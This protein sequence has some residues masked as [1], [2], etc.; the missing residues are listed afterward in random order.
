MDIQYKVSTTRNKNYDKKSIDYYEK[1]KHKLVK[2]IQAI[3]FNPNE[4]TDTANISG[5]S[6]NELK[7]VGDNIVLNLKKTRSNLIELHKEPKFIKEIHLTSTRKWFIIPEFFNTDSGKT[8]YGQEDSSSYIEDK[9]NLNDFTGEVGRYRFAGKPDVFTVDVKILFVNNTDIN[10]KDTVKNAK[11]EAIKTLKEFRAK[12]QTISSIDKQLTAPN[13]LKN[14]PDELKPTYKV[15]AGGGFGGESEDG[16]FGNEKYFIHNE[17]GTFVKLAQVGKLRRV[18]EA[19]KPRTK[20]YHVGVEI[21]FVSK[22][23]KYELAQ[24]L[25]KNG[26]HEFV[27]LVEDGSLRAEKD[28]KHCHEITILA[29]EQLIHAVLARVL[30]AINENGGSQVSKKC[31]LHVH[32]DMRHR[33]RKLCFYNLQKSQ[34]LMYAMNPRSRVDGTQADGKVDGT[35]YSKPITIDDVDEAINTFSASS[36]RYNGINVLALSKHQT[37]EIRIH[38]GSTNFEKISNWVKILTSIVN[39][40]EKTEQAHTDVSEFCSFYGLD[41]SIVKYMSDR[42]AKFKDKNGKH[43]TLDEVA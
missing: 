39:K 22:Y 13:L 16:K 40:Q 29:P 7:K 24:L 32:L 28:F 27:Q 20:D 34:K 25:Y 3:A 26:V 42:I 4:E 19:K 37:I 30:K 23:N 41:D 15:Y 17:K 12:R 5:L 9:E 14:L 18:F 6:L 10:I 38:S 36:N 43:I 8:E 35:V 21:E 31:G 1:L 33:D 11:E 2:A